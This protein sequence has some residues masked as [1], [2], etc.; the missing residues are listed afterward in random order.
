MTLRPPGGASS[1]G[2]QHDRPE[3]PP[4]QAAA[5]ANAAQGGGRLCSVHHTKPSRE[6][7]LGLQLNCGS[8]CRKKA[9]RWLRWASG[10]LGR[11]PRMHLGHAPAGNC[12]QRLRRQAFSNS[13]QERDNQ[14]PSGTYF[15][16]HSPRLFC[17]DGYDRI[18]HGTADKPRKRNR[19]KTRLPGQILRQQA[20]LPPR[21]S[22]TYHLDGLGRH[23]AWQEPAKKKAGE[24]WGEGN[25]VAKKA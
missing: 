24:G 5:H 11:R 8:G 19:V 25:K 22:A 20:A 10:W 9:R 18:L 23:N 3:E 1:G 17:T 16:L 13:A 2:S 15:I 12:C 4:S 6:G 14:P 21:A 7:S